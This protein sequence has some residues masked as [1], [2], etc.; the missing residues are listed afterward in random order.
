[1]PGYS[2]DP[3]DQHPQGSHSRQQRSATG[4]QGSYSQSQ[5]AGRYNAQ[6]GRRGGAYA[7]Q[8]GGAH[9]KHG[10][11]AP[12]ARGGRN[13]I[14]APA[15]RRK[16]PFVVIVLALVAMLAFCIHA[17]NAGGQAQDQQ[18]ADT[19]TQMSESAQSSSSTEE[20]ASSTATDTEL[21]PLRS[22]E[23]RKAT[24]TST[25][26][27]KPGKK[28][29][30]L[31]FDDG[32][33]T[34]TH[35]I[36]KILNKY[37]VHATWFVIGTRGHLEYVK[38]IWKA[39][40]QVALH[41]YTHEYAT[42]YASVSAYYDGLDKLAGKAEKYLGF[43]PTLFRFPGGSVNDFNRAVRSGLKAEAEKRHW[44]YFDWNVSSGD[45]SGNNVPASKLIKNIKT[46]SKGNNSSC[47]L[48]HDT[49]A[50]ATTVEALP[51]IIEYYKSQGYTFDVL[52][53]DSYG[54][55]F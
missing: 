38:D 11:Y 28:V 31:T 3:R 54:Y 49:E 17:C 6:G 55:Q 46:E 10:I 4:R 1:M 23:E 53:A 47:V 12:D 34:E 43:K 45:A 22:E 52:T 36:L 39:G 50:K 42:D 25:N 40:N 32:P 33:S 41:S 24:S 20:Q 9:P 15:K 7:S 30:Y 18:A 2:R 37:G 19:S 48:M 44:H 21:S 26:K 5:A 14:Y 27:K 29:C 8:Q 16:W 35:K 51:K 13:M